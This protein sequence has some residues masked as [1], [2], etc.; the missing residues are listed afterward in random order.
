[1]QIKVLSPALA[2]LLMTACA[3]SGIAEGQYDAA[4]PRHVAAR[5]GAEAETRTQLDAMTPTGTLLGESRYDAC[6]EYQRNWKIQDPN[7]IECHLHLS[8]A[9]AVPNVVE[10]IREAKRRFAAAG[11][12]NDAAFDD[13]LR[14][15]T[16]AN[17]SD[18]NARYKR[19]TDLPQVLFDCGD[20]RVQAQLINPAAD[21]MEQDLANIDAMVGARRVALVEQQG[22]D[23][24]EVA[25]ARGTQAPLVVLVAID[26]TYFS[27]RW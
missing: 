13:S 20:K 10:G 24:N 6:F 18:G 27:E 8:R 9:V 12:P 11:C 25:A 15:Y 3:S 1:M 22:Y 19:N 4:S 26:R 21:M 14:Y 23:A 2:A 16:E 5:A 7:R 17:G